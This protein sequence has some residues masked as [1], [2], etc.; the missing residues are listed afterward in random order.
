MDEPKLMVDDIHVR[1]PIS[2]PAGGIEFESLHALPDPG[3]PDQAVVRNVPVLVDWLNLGDIVRIGNNLAGAHPILEVMVASGNVHV[4]VATDDARDL[5]DR[6]DDRFPH[7]AVRSEGGG[8]GF[9]SISIHP[10]ADVDEVLDVIDDWLDDQPTDAGYS[11]VFET[12]LG[13][14]SWP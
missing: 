9:L 13:S 14:V 8:I 10:D 11:P 4:V 5:C 1:A 3:D 6:L 2:D 7:H 12:K